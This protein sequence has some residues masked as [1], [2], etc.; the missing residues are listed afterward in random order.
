M[1]TQKYVDMRRQQLELAA[2]AISH[3]IGS[4]GDNGL[5][6]GGMSFVINQLAVVEAQIFE[7]HY[8]PLTYQQ[9]MTISTEGGPGVTSFVYKTLDFVGQGKRASNNADDI[10]YADVSFAQH[11]SP[12]VLGTVGYHYSTEELR[13]SAVL[14]IALPAYKARAAMRAYENHMNKVALVG[15]AKDLWGLCNNPQV[16]ILPAPAPWTN[17]T[18]YD[19][20]LTDTNNLLGA[21]YEATLQNV[22]ANTLLLP[23]SVMLQLINVRLPYTGE[24]VLDIVRND[25]F[26]T[27]SGGGDL[28]IIQVPQLETASPTGARRIVAYNRDAD[29][30]VMHIPMPLTFLPPQPVNLDLKIPGEYKYGGVEIRYYNTIRYMDGV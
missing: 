21:V 25:N 7:R 29:N 4:V 2:P 3:L 6:P 9:L 24:M 18:T 15:E 22:F 1:L 27:V 5:V 8:A 26:T 10:P 20:I 14:A 12:V 11:I 17:T 30:L 28:L 13:Q 23:P 16:T 19:V